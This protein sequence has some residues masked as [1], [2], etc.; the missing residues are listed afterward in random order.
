MTAPASLEPARRAGAQVPFILL[1]RPFLLVAAFL[2]PAIVLGHFLHLRAL[3]LFHVLPLFLLLL[4][5]IVLVAW[6]STFSMPVSMLCVSYVGFLLGAETS[7]L[8]PEHVRF[9]M[10]DDTAYEL[11]GVV[12][13]DPISLRSG[14]RQYP[15]EVAERCR[16]IIEASRLRN[17]DGAEGLWRDATGKVQVYAPA[18]EAGSL[19]YGDKVGVAGKAFLPEPRRNPGGFDMR[20]YLARESIHVCL[21]AD[22][23]SHVDPG[24]G[25]PLFHRVHSLKKKLRRSLSAGN[26]APDTIAFLRAIILG[27]RREVEEDFKE[28]LRRTNTMHILAISGLHV[29]IMAFFIYFLLS[30]LLLV[31]QSIS[32]LVTI[33]AVAGYS[34]LT[35]LH[36]P[37]F[38]ASV[39]S[40]VFL[41]GPILKRRSDSLNS[42]AAA[43]VVILCVRPGDLVTAGFQLSFAVVLAI[44]LL[45]DRV[46]LGLVAMLG[47]RP[48]PGFLT[49]GAWRRRI[50]RALEYP[51]RLFAVSV[52]AFIGSFPLIV[53]YFHYISFFSP[54]CNMV[55]LSLVGF[56]VPLG[57]L[58]GAVGLLSLTA[59]GAVNALNS[60]LI[61]GLRAVVEFFAM[62]IGAV[63]MSPP[64]VMFVFAFYGTICIVGFAR[65]V[66]RVALPAASL[67]LV[68]LGVFVCGEMA[69]RH[70]GS[71]EVTFL[72][73]GQ[74]DCAFVEFPDGRRMLVD[75]G[76]VTKSDVGRH[77]IVPFLRWSGV[78]E[79]DAV[80]VTHYDP[81]HINALS[82][83]LRDI[84]TRL[85][86]LRCGPPA[87]NIPEA[88]RLL[89]LAQAK[90]IPLRLVGAGEE[91]PLS[92]KTESRVLNPPGE[93]D[94]SRFSENDLSVVLK[95]DYG[96]ASVLLCG[97]IES[98]VERRLLREGVP[99]QSEVIKVPHHGSNTSSL[100]AFIRGVQPDVAVISCGRGN[101]YRHPSPQ[102]LERYALLGI[103]V[104]RTDRDGAIRVR[105]FPNRLTVTTT[106]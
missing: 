23:I 90:R 25:N 41:L 81:D 8:P 55:V 44:L 57:L 4:L 103:R 32:S 97:D 21:R 70:P 22:G 18:E 98:K 59:A 75:G 88:Q 12:I 100:E 95:L 19:K 37:V 79:L 83:V 78:N 30:R 84:R 86:I 60:S 26:V 38:R 47:L 52:A 66:K 67:A 74:G 35:G 1:K 11:V 102:V 62:R 69:R 64:P 92:G 5:A 61:S 46:F 73:V 39:M 85:L 27:E 72:D 14:V 106:L 80:V 31:P 77:V 58:S 34:L 56:I 36:P 87:P 3:T 45:S 54:L 10:N 93:D 40:A 63:N 50:Y 16:F 94:L 15:G 20:K 49:V 96:G 7:L 53:H 68:T 2:V 43:A 42:L 13:E 89:S 65:T 99:V 6:H 51:L 9:A 17:T 101:I 28:A 82:D 91:L 71:V 105:V 76:S 29:G 24:H 33:A 48:D 104:F